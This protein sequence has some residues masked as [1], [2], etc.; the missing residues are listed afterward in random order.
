MLLLDMNK[1]GRP[2]NTI[3][4]IFMS[5]DKTSNPNGCWEWTKAKDH[6]GYGLTRFNGK[7]IGAHRLSYL[8]HKGSIPAGLFVC[9]TCDNPSCCNPDHLWLG[10]NQENQIDLRDKGFKWNAASKL[11]INDILAIRSSDLKIKELAIQYDVTPQ[12]IR[13]IKSYKTWR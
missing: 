6:D 11:N 10:T 1:R 7:M 5:L 9:H 12:N 2:K 13:L 3:E 4:Y 8:A